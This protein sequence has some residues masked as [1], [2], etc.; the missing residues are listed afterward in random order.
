VKLLRRALAGWRHPVRALA[1]ALAAFA[2]S[3]GV[4]LGEA[5]AAAMI[6][7]ILGVVAGELLGRSRVRPTVG[8]AGLGLLAFVLWRFAALAVGTEALA[9]LAGPANAL[10]TASVLRF[11]ALSFSVVAALRM[12]AVRRPAVTALE[13]GLVTVA[14]TSVFASHR[15]GV[16]ARPL[17]LS[18]W[19][20]QQGIDPAQVLLAIGGAAVTLLAVL[21][22]ADTR[23]GR[24]LSSLVLLVL[25][26]LSA[27][28]VIQVVGTPMPQSMSELGISDAGMGQPPRQTPDA[29]NGRGPNRGPDGGGGGGGPDAGDAGDHRGGGDAGDGGA[30]A[31][32]D[33]GDGGGSSGGDGGDGGGSSGP[34]D[35]GDGGAGGAGA[36]AGDVPMPNL[37][38]I[39]G[40]AGSGA[41]DGGR[42]I[43]PSA[44]ERLD[45][46][47]SPSNSPTPMAVVV[48]DDD[49]SPPSGAYYF[50]QEVW[51]QVSGPRL[52]RTTR[53]DVDGDVVDDF[54]TME[55]RVRDPATANG[56]AR[57]H[58]LIAV[59]A[60]HTYPFALESPIRYQPAPN[61][62]PQRFLR[63]W[64]FESL[65]QSIDYRRLT[66]HAS[67]DPRWTPEVRAYFTQAP[68]DPRYR[69][70][71]QRI[72][73]QRLPQRLRSDP[74]AQALAIKLY[75]DHELIYS[76]RA[77]HA[78]VPDPTADFLF[79]NRTG[80][81]VH[82][83]HS[84]VYLWR[85]LGI[86]SRI[87][88]GYHSDE[89]NR[90]GGSTILLRGGDAHAW[91]EL[92]VTGYGWIVLDIAAERNL[93]PPGQGTDEDLQRILGEMARQV[94]PDPEQPRPR[95]R[96]PQRHYG[97]D[98][99]YGILGLLGVA[100]ASLYLIK[101][102]RR[103][104]V[105][106]SAPRSLPRVGYRKALD[107]MAE[108]GLVREHGEPRER[109]ASR[110]AA[111]AP[112][113][114]RLTS[115]HLSAKL[116]DPSKRDPDAEALSRRQWRDG[117]RSLR[118][119]LRAGT[120]RWRRVLG[121]L[122][123]ASWLDAR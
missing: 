96:P 110:V 97:R 72:V 22:V 118:R 21:L 111:V 113:F 66:G 120:K 98:L 67:G 48:L 44:S 117:L 70:L 31:G 114:T 34:T 90:R 55:L 58:G 12:M 85:S 121:L 7:A 75:L 119:E 89:S 19:A 53:T 81:C 24:A 92:Y 74:F 88:A 49:Y 32:G 60:Q 36:D 76:T 91:P 10:V 78:G 6:G 122:N 103:A 46:D 43:P 27:V 71:A 51:S 30:G 68:T 102:W 45:D 47:Q 56:R 82:F 109:F 100:L 23:S 38:D 79:G 1:M 52:V 63:A 65:S 40:G 106:L 69:E 61:P 94:P 54:P 123:P 17:W 25:L 104:R 26:A 3:W 15:E 16:I 41:H 28:G 77:R 93:D 57:V 115:M 95:D 33:A 87:S 64:R 29:G 39:D 42:P 99:G 116:G 105:T 20:W 80:Y 112:T 2:L 37:I 9:E 73:N 13:L 83:A 8:V 84:A 86:P 62:N 50:R 14:F 101:L 108:A 18:D 107:L 35:A 4:A 59:L 11:G 5:L